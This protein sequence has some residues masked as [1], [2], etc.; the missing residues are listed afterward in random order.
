MEA[1][2]GKAMSALGREGFPQLHT[3]FIFKKFFIL[4]K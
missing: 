2:D 1:F 3:N 4:L